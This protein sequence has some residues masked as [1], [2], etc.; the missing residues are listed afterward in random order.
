MIGKMKGW[1]FLPKRFSADGTPSESTI[2][3]LKA[4]KSKL[5]KRLAEIPGLISRTQNSISL[6][7]QDIT[8]LGSINNRK[9]RQWEKENGKSVEQAIYD[10][11]NLIVAFK[12]DMDTL[13]N[14]KNRIPTQIKDVDLQISTII[15]GESTGLSKGISK[16]TAKQLGEITLQKER[17]EIANQ[18]AIQQAQL[19]KVQI[20]TQQVQ[21]QATKTTMSPQMKWGIIIGTTIIIA[22][23]G[24]M[25]YKNKQASIGMPQPM[26]L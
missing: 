23:I 22:I 4:E 9:A 2:E 7:T 15:Q 20:E 25:I 8:W 10:G 6:I 12:A 1:N 17:T 24:Y 13:I 18:T 11:K 21:Q 5:E 26:K 19:E 3:T 16:E 14:E